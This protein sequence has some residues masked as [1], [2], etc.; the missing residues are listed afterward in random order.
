[1]AKVTQN[2]IVLNVKCLAIK[3]LT[4]QQKRKILTKSLIPQIGKEAQQIKFMK[5]RRNKF[6][7]LNAEISNLREKLKSR[8]N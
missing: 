4:N 8:I 1:M 7:F 6:S 3:K 5:S 2:T